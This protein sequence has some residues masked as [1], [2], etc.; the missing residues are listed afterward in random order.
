MSFEDDGPTRTSAFNPD[1][2]PTYKIPKQPN[3]FSKR[4]LRATLA[5][6][7]RS[8]VF[9]VFVCIFFAYC[10]ISVSTGHGSSKRASGLE[11]CKDWD[12]EEYV[13]DHLKKYLDAKASGMSHQEILK[14]VFEVCHSLV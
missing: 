12:D 13:K 10:V 9:L 14:D 8:K 11:C 7:I 2:I 6:V 1:V 4:S 5:S 3:W